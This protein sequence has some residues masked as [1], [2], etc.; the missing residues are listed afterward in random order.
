MY[1]LQS[2]LE[3]Q[4]LKI[5]T[6]VLPAADINLP[7][8]GNLINKVNFDWNDQTVLDQGNFVKNTFLA[9]YYKADD[10]LGRVCTGEVHPIK[11]KADQ[12]QDFGKR[13]LELQAKADFAW[14]AAPERAPFS[15]GGQLVENA[16][17]ADF[18][19]GVMFIQDGQ[20]GEPMGL[21]SVLQSNG[22]DAST[23]ALR[24]YLSAI[25]SFHIRFY[26]VR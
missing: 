8:E 6:N 7:G 24:M 25:A 13:L 14:Q 18:P 3:D 17:F 22:V 12:K 19:N 9:N 4:D 10:K 21:S 16:G 2:M 15:I 5:N 20:A 23:D 11:A 1:V 26:V